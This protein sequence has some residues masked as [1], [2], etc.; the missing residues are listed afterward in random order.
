[1][2]NAILLVALPLLGA[3]LLPLIYRRHMIVGYWTAPLILL[4]NLLIALILLASDGTQA[5]AMG[6]FA[7]PMGIV[8]YVDKLALLFVIMIVL[9]ML[10]LWLG[11]KRGQVREETLFLLLVGGSCGLALSGDLFNIYVFY[12]IVSVASYGLAA[13]RGT[14]A[15]YAAS[16]RFLIL[17]SLGSSLL[18]LGIALIYGVTGTLNVAQ[19]AELAPDKLNSSIGLA[20]FVLMLIGF[21]V[22]AELFPVNTWVPEVYAT[23]PARVTALL[24]GIV[25]KLALLIVLRLVVLIYGDAPTA[26]MLLLSLGVLGVITGE[27]AAL[28]A[29]DLRQVLAFSSIGQLGLIAIAFSIPGQAGIIAG[30][31]IALHHAIVKPALFMLTESWGV[32]LNRLAGAVQSSKLSVLLFL[33]MALSLIGIPPLPG[34]W[35]KFLLVTAALKSS[36][37]QYQMAIAVVLIATVIETAYFFKIIRLMF[38]Q[39]S[40]SLET[41][42][43]SDLAPALSFMILLFLGL[44]MLGNLSQGLTSVA[45]DGANRQG[46]IEN[47]GLFH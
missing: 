25:S 40:S 37:G 6:G 10:I 29:T 42:R 44:F 18:L 12:E 13:S 15:G 19:I 39:K 20:A 4:I 47:T 7:A 45:E 22:K 8:F 5:I 9:G 2:T 32:Q 35:A 33:I 23:A 26:L 41:P 28:R 36:V 34:F 14:G 27:L 38:Q 43:F 16:V 21:G 30:I 31:A 17:G 24:G 3:F 46:Y 1:M 11:K